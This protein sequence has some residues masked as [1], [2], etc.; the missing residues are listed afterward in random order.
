MTAS[1]SAEYQVV[2]MIHQGHATF[3]T[4]VDG[5]RANVRVVRWYLETDA[6]GFA[7]NNLDNPPQF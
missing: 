6:D 5:R 7:P 1:S 2:A 3:F 4:D